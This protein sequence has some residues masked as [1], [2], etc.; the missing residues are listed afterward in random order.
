MK[1]AVYVLEQG[2]VVARERGRLV[3]RA[4]EEVRSSTPLMLVS[5]VVL[6]GQVHVTMPALHALLHHGVPLALLRQ[7]GRVRGRLEPPGNPHVALRRQQL[8]ASD[9]PVRRLVLA[10][11]FVEGKLRNQAALLRRRARTSG[12]ASTLRQS[13]E[14]ILHDVE[15]LS[16]APSLDSVLGTEGAAGGVYF[17]A[18]RLL[19]DELDVAFVR[20]DRRAQDPVNCLLNYCSVLL[21]ETVLG[22]ISAVGL[23]PHVSFLHRPWRGRPTLA[24]DL[25]E[26]FRPPLLDSVVLALLGLGAVRLDDVTPTAAGPRLS[27]AARAAAVQRYRGRLQ[28]SARRYDEHAPA[29]TYLDAVHRQARRLRR[30]IDVGDDYEALRWR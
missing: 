28:A 12:H 18:L 15:S 8:D 14:R 11:A 23:D 21:R 4:G 16:T 13:A 3:V 26:E 7:D 20:R 6:F 30:A 9:D 22:A 25:M 10:R 27:R 17:R 5:E 1:V 29:G 19:T 2:A 24:F